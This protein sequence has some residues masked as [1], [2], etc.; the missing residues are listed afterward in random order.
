MNGDAG[1]AEGLTLRDYLAVVWRRKWLILLVTLVATGAAYVFADRQ[2]DMYQAAADLIYESQIDVSNP[3]ST[4]TYTDPYERDLEMRAIANVLA[5]PD[6]IRRAEAILDETYVGGYQSNQADG[7]VRGTTADGEPVA[8]PSASASDDD[9]A[10]DLPGYAVSSTVPEDT[11]S[12]SVGSNVVSIIGDSTDPRLAAAAANAYAEA[13]VSWRAERQQEQIDKAITVVKDQM[14]RY[15]DAAQTSSDYIILQERLRDL[16]I[17]R[18]TATGNFRVLV[19]AQEPGAPYEPQPLRSAILGLGVGLFAGIGL[20]F[21]LEQ[22]D[23]RLRRQDEVARILRQPIIGRIP[24]ISKRLLGESAMVTL[25]HPEGHAAEAFRMIR[26]NLE[27]MSIDNDIRS[28]IVT[29]CIQG[30]GKS[31]SVANLAVSMALAGKKIVVV[32]G[33][34]RRPRLHTYFG[35]ENKI[36]VSTVA[37]GKTPLAQALEPVEL[38]PQ[39]GHV[40]GDFAEWAKGADA[41]SRLFVLPSGPLPPNP[42]E[43]VNSRRFGQIIQALEKEADLVIVDSP[44]MLAVGDTAALAAK[45][46]GLVFLVDMH[47]LKR[48]VL[49]QAVEQLYKLPVSLMGVILRADG[50]GRPG[51]YG[52]YGAPYGYYEYGRDGSG[53]GRRRGERSA[54]RGERSARSDDDGGSARRSSGD[55]RSSSS[56]S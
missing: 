31:V 54:R 22:F 13:Y 47:V 19:P 3:L 40:E 52:Y 8:Q 7:G 44:A 28:L 4:Y 45:V 11:S 29:S 30:E 55:S 21:L 42:G 48:P 20:A 25:R 23:T 24:R 17:L 36:G 35:V 10:Y 46:D 43:I 2:A 37:T 50:T 5:S 14:A 49:Q 56:R 32:D 27:F 16:Q 38:A 51:R 39:N 41:R 34:L 1:E 53:G 33:D 18:E 6:M 9:V 15:R 12:N 26:T